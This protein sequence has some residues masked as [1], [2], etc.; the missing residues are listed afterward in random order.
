M[1][2][3]LH[4]V[5]PSDLSL[6]TIQIIGGQRDTIAEWVATPENR[7]FRTEEIAPGFY[8][9][10]ITPA[11]VAPRSVV[12][13]VR[14]G[15]SNTV[16]LPPFSALV[17]SGSNTNF[18]DAENRRTVSNVADL[19]EFDRFKARQLKE[20]V[21]DDRSQPVEV[22]RQKS[23]ISLGLS[24]ERHGRDA[25]TS[26]WGKTRIDMF[27]GRVE[28]EIPEDHSRDP[29]ISQ[30]V[31]LAMAVEGVKIERCLLPLYRGGT[32]IMVTAPPFS[33]DDLELSVTPIDP[34]LRAL[35]RALDGG[36]SAE[37]KALDRDIISK[38]WGGRLSG[39]RPDPWTC[40]LVG[41]L[42]IRF[43]HVLTPLDEEW[44]V[45]LARSAAWAFDAHI[46]RAS[47]LLTQAQGETASSQTQAI[48]RAIDLLAAA[49]A[50]RSPYYR[51]TNQLFSEIANGIASF[52]EMR[53]HDVNPDAI[54]TFN[55]LFSRWRSELPLQR[56]AGASFT[57]LSRDPAALKAHGVVVPN[58]NPSGTLSS[59][60]TQVVFEG[61]VSAGRITYASGGPKP[62]PGSSR[63][64]RKAEAVPEM[65]RQNG[66]SRAPEIPAL[67]RPIIFAGDPVR[68]RFGGESASKG[69]RLSARF[70]AAKRPDWVTIVLT[71][72][73]SPS[74]YIGLGDFA[75]FV[76]HP[77]FSPSIVKVVFR[78][79]RAE[80][81]LQA[82]GGFT[83][84][85]WIPSVGA[86]LECNL[87]QVDGAPEPI[88][89]R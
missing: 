20:A 68:E 70:E 85:V 55:R 71:V 29:W 50:A 18:F 57:W 3:S 26:F 36:S 89:L 16:V 77:T 54:Q 61:E 30:R 53:D 48:V 72:E 22:S 42:S 58:R 80:L 81:R 59:R 27:S 69:C 75:W 66:D 17:S 10:E 63:P 13:E 37:I 5:A 45:S 60:G 24:E 76:L 15:E 78:S 8:S 12:F 82:W 32:R 43:S 21:V 64:L 62:E 73:A 79:R 39:G 19:Q 7:N 1:K 25:F 2:T 86:E 49:Q 34:E 46:I 83:V 47:H 41:L 52:L 88:R 11:G 87:A 44:V 67:A 31:R 51:Y 74:T 56:G 4:L 33:P 35:V 14:E 38:F 28:L 23:R 84:G 9:S 6:G 65:E 40:M